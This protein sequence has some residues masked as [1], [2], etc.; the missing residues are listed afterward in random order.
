MLE[1]RGKRFPGAA[2]QEFMIFFP[3]CLWGMKHTDCQK[4]DSGGICPLP[5]FSM[6]LTLKGVVQR[7]NL[8]SVYTSSEMS[9]FIIN[10]KFPFLM[11][12]QPFIYKRDLSM[13]FWCNASYYRQAMLL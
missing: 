11:L 5:G 9:S 1:T 10:E 3:T 8:P 12:C 6:H 13:R 2:S 7:K 4:Y